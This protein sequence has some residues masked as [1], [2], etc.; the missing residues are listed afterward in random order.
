MRLR[1]T[2]FLLT[3][4]L[5]TG[6]SAGENTSTGPIE[7]ETMTVSSSEIR[8]TIEFS[9]LLEPGSEAFLVSPGGILLLIAVSEGDSVKAGETIAELSGDAALSEAA[10]A[11]AAE[12]RAALS[13]QERAANDAVR[14]RELYEAGAISEAAL[15]GALA[16]STAAEA[17][18]DGARY[19]R[20]AVVAGERTGL[21][22]APFDGI[23]GTVRG[24]NGEF[25]SQGDIIA[26]V[27]G[28]GLMVR[29]LVP[30]RHLLEIRPGMTA[31]FLPALSEYPSLTGT[32]ESVAR[33]V[34]PLTGLV[35]VTARF[36]TGE[37]PAVRPG[38]SGVLSIELAM[39]SGAVVIPADAVVMVGGTMQVPVLVDD[40]R[41][42]YRTVELGIQAGDSV[43]VV[44]GISFGEEVILRSTAQLSQGV[45][46]VRIGF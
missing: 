16:A 35:P 33:S 19:A 3:I 44:S 22:K 36:S 46:A 38:V 40:G 8:R 9:A 37:G 21:L 12:V 13:R 32:V 39:A 25:S 43:Q 14:S 29:L 42:D 2:E 7:V 20:A 10:A 15:L 18:V 5:L 23:V 34:D 26:S 11:T 24:R 17:A 6:C 45:R 1:T 41:V 27:I 31:V 30:E 4:S 28:D